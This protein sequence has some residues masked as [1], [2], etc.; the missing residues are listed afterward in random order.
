[1]GAIAKTTDVGCQTVDSLL[2]GGRG[3]MAE[4][5]LMEPEP[6]NLDP[7]L[8]DE[9]KRKWLEQEQCGQTDGSLDVSSVG[10]GEVISS[11]NTVHWSVC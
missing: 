10:L 3:P 7:H 9:H 11:L 4:E 2:H 5:E 6:T 1:M 8:E